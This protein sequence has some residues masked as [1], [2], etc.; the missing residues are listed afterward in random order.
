MHGANEGRP[1]FLF[2]GRLEKLKGLQNV[3][4]LF[5]HYRG[6]DLLVVGHGDYAATLRQQARGL[7][8]VKFRGQVHPSEISAFYRNTVAVLAPSLCYE[9]FS[10]TTAEALAHGT[11]V[12]GR[13]IGAL[14]EL[15]EET[16]GGLLFETPGQCRE[17]MERLR[18]DPALR[19][20]LGARGR[21]AALKQWT[22]DVHL[23]RYL[24]LVRSLISRRNPT[25]RIGTVAGSP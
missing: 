4:P 2:V 19:A 22:V 21:S 16:G 24:E 11:P 7:E 5:A 9:T 17:A 14:A 13:R 6:A 18:T 8:N 20:D 15:I 23:E 3:I 10:L 12:I 25:S 1:F